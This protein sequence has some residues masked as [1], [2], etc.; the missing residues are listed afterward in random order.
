MGKNKESSLESNDV[1][2]VKLVVIQFYPWLIFNSFMFGLLIV[3]QFVM[4]SLNKEKLISQATDKSHLTQNVV[5]IVFLFLNCFSRITLILKK[6][7]T[8]N[9]LINLK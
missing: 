4:K 8:F 2:L 3:E 7:K 1:S 6:V 5:K 9:N